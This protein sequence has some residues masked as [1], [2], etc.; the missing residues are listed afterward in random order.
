MPE[1]LIFL[2]NLA[3]ESEY[4]NIMNRGAEFKGPRV[5]GHDTWH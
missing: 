5:R 4:D 2:I 3:Y 1:F